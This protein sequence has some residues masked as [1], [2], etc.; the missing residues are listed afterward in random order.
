MCYFFIKLHFWAVILVASSLSQIAI[1]EYEFKERA[2]T[3]C[4]PKG[5]VFQ[6]LEDANIWCES[7]KTC[8]GVLVTNTIVDATTTSDTPT[9]NTSFHLCPV[10]ATITY[11]NDIQNSFF[12]KLISGKQF[13]WYHTKIKLSTIKRL[14]K[15]SCCHLFLLWTRPLWPNKLQRKSIMPNS[16]QHGKALLC[17]RSR[18][19][20]IQRMR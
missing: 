4:E 9:F 12:E 2:K 5:N 1:S 19:H 18:I 7:D 10:T 15:W 13:S 11:N 17:M 14:G 3:N 20:R 16:V 6:S 8:Q